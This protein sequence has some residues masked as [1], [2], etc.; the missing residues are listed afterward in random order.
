VFDYEYKV[1]YLRLPI[2]CVKLLHAIILWYA[3]HLLHAIHV[4]YT[5]QLCNTFIAYD[6]VIVCN[7]DMKNVFIVSNMYIWCAALSPVFYHLW[8][9]AG[10]ANANFYF[11]LTLV[12]NGAQVSRLCSLG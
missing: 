11:A 8:I 6:I 9:Y 10:S 5:M 3:M 4:F 12:F 2:Y 7:T 1:L